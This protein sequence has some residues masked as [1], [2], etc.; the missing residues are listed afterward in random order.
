MDIKITGLQSSLLPLFLRY[1]YFFKDIIFDA[2]KRKV[3]RFSRKL[4]Q[5]VPCGTLSSELFEFL[6]YLY[7][8]QRYAKFLFF[9]FLTV[10]AYLKRKSLRKLHCL[11]IFLC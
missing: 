3:R 5:L 6:R 1:W 9:G 11:K 8:Y 4:L 10:H 7:P 2:G